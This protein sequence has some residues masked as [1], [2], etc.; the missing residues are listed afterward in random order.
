VG[1]ENVPATI[2]GGVDLVEEKV[3]KK[4]ETLQKKKKKK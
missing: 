4:R 2:R 3:K 1:D